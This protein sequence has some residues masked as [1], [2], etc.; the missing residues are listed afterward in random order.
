MSVRLSLSKGEG[1]LEG[2]LMTQTRTET[3]SIGAVEVPAEAYWGAQTQRSIENFPFGAAE[4]MPM[5]LVHGLALVKQAV[6]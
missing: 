5:G 4:R 3:D 2:P 1:I 6:G